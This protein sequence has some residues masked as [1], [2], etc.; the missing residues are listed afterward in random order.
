M[1]EHDYP[2]PVE[3]LDGSK[4]GQL[5]CPE[6]RFERQ[7]TRDEIALNEPEFHTSCDYCHTGLMFKYAEGDKCPGCGRLGWWDSPYD[8]NAC[9]RACHFQAE[10]AMAQAASKEP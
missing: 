9:S 6:C 5:I 7:A 3:R 10:Y 4:P 2:I 8:D 1:S